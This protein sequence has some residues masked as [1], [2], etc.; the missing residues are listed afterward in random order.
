M[1]KFLHNYS[2]KKVP[3]VILGTLFFSIGLL[4]ASAHIEIATIREEIKT[5]RAIVAQPFVK[6]ERIEPIT[7]TELRIP[8]L[9]IDTK[10]ISV[11]VTEDGNMGVPE[12]FLEA[13]WF[14]K[15][16]KPGERGNAVI[17]AHVDNAKGEPA[18]FADISKI[19]IGEIIEVADETGETLSYRVTKTKLFTH[20]EED[21]SEVFGTSNK[22]N[23]NLITCD[24]EWNQ[25]LKTY[26]ERF[27]VFSELVE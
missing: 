16:A 9:A 2:F 5:N 17:A 25:E 7:P 27:V 23:L 22:R 26:E 13:G 10:V 11:G 21:T 15:G 14:D 3:T 4:A 20:S 12:S 24:G 8:S 18:V 6:A 19:S 1:N